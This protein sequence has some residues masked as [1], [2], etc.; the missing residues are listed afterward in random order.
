[1]AIVPIPGHFL[2]REFICNS[3]YYITQYSLE[4]DKANKG[5]VRETLDLYVQEVSTGNKFRLYVPL[6]EVHRLTGLDREACKVESTV[7]QILSRDITESC[8]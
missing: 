2:G 3:G 4:P 8:V 7:A 5:L 1:M 6:V